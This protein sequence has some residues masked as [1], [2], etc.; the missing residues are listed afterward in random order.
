MRGAGYA[1]PVW[2]WCTFLNWFVGQRHWGR[3]ITGLGSLFALELSAVLSPLFG[4]QAA[5]LTP[6]PFRRAAPLQRRT[7]P[8]ARSAVPDQ[9]AWTSTETGGGGGKGKDGVK[10]PT[11]GSGDDE[12]EEERFLSLSEAEQLAAAKGVQLP[13]DFAAIAAAEGLRLSVLEAF[14]ALV[15]GSWLTR[16]LAQLIPAFRDRLIADR[17]FLF[18]VL[19]EVAI[20][21]GCATVAEV[22]KR[23]DEFWS[24]FEFYLS[25]LL[26]GLVL[27]VVLV[28]LLAPVAVKGRGR[29]KQTGWLKRRLAALPSAVFEASTPARPYSTAA[30]V[31]C[32][33]V[34]AVEYGVAGTICGI[35]GQGLANGLMQVKR[36]CQGGARDGDVEL[37]PVVGT[38]LVWG[39]FMGVSSNVRYQIVFGLERLVELTIA[40][41]V[42]QVREDGAVL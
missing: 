42:P 40:K 14:F 34:K 24:E 33:G 7:A 18:K 31:G 30:R 29:P 6:L 9:P 12:G 41:R 10:P 5:G 15:S 3:I 37:P 36:R 22:R 17:L 32:L 28:S 13:A 27:D 8:V 16:T 4:S 2:P 1:G 11:G 19:A 39:L 26:V 35:L 21:T 25:D 23:G 20:D 38:G